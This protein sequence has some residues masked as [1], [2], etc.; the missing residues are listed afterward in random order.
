MSQCCCTSA[1]CARQARSGRLTLLWPSKG[2][3]KL[4]LLCA[5]LATSL[6][7]VVLLLSLVLFCAVV[8]LLLPCMCYSAD[9]KAMW[10]APEDP[11]SIGECGALFECMLLVLC[12]CCECILVSQQQQSHR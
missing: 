5:A 8:R 4:R 9:L 2:L 1:G 11:W 10:S 6:V 12:A 7:T 3:R